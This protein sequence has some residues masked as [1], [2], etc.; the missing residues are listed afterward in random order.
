MAGT[1]I[2]GAH[3][4]GITLSD[5]KTENPATIAVGGYVTNEGSANNG[6]ALF[7]TAA[8]AWTITNL[9]R[10]NGKSGSSSNGIQLRAGGFVTNGESGLASGLIT[11][12]LYGIEIEGKPGTVVNYGQIL[13]LGRN[14]GG[15][16][17]KAGGTVFSDGLIEGTA[18]GVAIGGGAG[19]V[20]NAGTIVSPAGN[21]VALLSGGAV[22]N[23]GK[24]QGRASGIEII[25]KAG[26]VTN[27]GVILGIGTGVGIC[28][29][30]G[31]TVT[32][33]TGGRITA[34]A[35]DGVFV[36]GGAA[37]VTNLGL[38]VGATATSGAAVYL[39]GGGIVTN[40][41]SGNTLG[42]ICGRRDG[43]VLNN[44]AGR[45]TNFG[46]IISTS[47]V[48]INGSLRGVGVLLGAGGTVVNGAAGK[49]GGRALISAEGI[50]VYVGG[51]A[52]TPRPG[53]VGTVVNYGTIR[54]SGVGAVASSAVVLVSG[55]RVV[56]H[57]LIESAGLTGVAFLNQAGT[58]TNFRSIV[59]NAT[60]PSGVGV[61][62]EDGGLVR[63]EAKALIT[64]A[65]NDGVV[66][67][68]A[69][70]TV[71]NLGIVV[72]GHN[73]DGAAVY[74]GHGGSITNGAS[75][76][77]GGLIIGRRS[78]VV[79][80]NLAGKVTNFGT[81][82]STSTA[83]VGGSSKGAG[84][85][86]GAGG[87]LINGGPGATGALIRAAEFGVYGGGIDGV[88][89]P[90][91]VATVV[92]YG[93][94]QSTGTGAIG[95]SAVRL[96][97]GGTVTNHGLIESAGGRGISFGNKRGTVTNFGSVVSTA[98][99]THGVGVYLQLGGQV[100]NEAGA[101]ISAT[102]DDS[103]LVK[104]G[105]AK[106]VNLGTIEDFKKGGVAVYLGGG[107]VVI[108]GANGGPEGAIVS[109]GSGV[110]VAHAAGRVTNFGWITSTGSA[111]SGAVAVELL[112]G[113]DVINRGLIKSAEGSAIAIDHEAGSVTNS[114][115]VVST[116]IGTAGAAI[117]LQDGGSVVNRRG[118]LVE[119]GA[120]PGILVKRAAGTVINSGTIES[121]FG[122]GVYLAAG[123]SLTNQ[124]GALIDGGVHGVYLTNPNGIVINHGT[125]EGGSAGFATLGPGHETLINFG[126]IE[127]TAG[128]AR[129]AVEI[130]G[131]VGG[132][133]LI[134]E[135][136]AVFVGA[137]LGGG[138][139]EIEFIGAVADMTAVDG[140]AKIV[141]A[142]GVH[143]SLTLTAANFVD[144][145]GGVITV[146]DGNRG[147]TV[148]AA[149]V[150]NAII[151]HAGSGADV[152]IG[153][154]GNDIFYAGGRT[155]M[156]GGTGTNEFVFHHPG[157]NTI[158]DFAISTTNEL[159]FSNN[160]FDLGLKNATMTPMVLPSRLV[161]AN[162]T[163]SFTN[164]HQRFAYDTSNGDLFYSATGTTAN[165]HLVVVL[166]GAP[167]LTTTPN[168]HLFYIT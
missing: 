31:G 95:S 166:T 59:S 78:G 28:L 68:N 105:R 146:F 140:F 55:G 80:K 91:A 72:G 63:N 3:L 122:N 20:S 164:K 19:T 75:G 115:S 147:N 163:G 150:A 22:T 159:V 152:L 39:G 14:G 65:R 167:P 148:S 26:T 12:N 89:K 135:P 98:T 38:I 64:A 108:N 117:Y 84:V 157:R 132:T 15:V 107:G 99:G 27:S 102:G 50:G 62:L 7:G 76:T 120:N 162:S 11:A 30:Q 149:G 96:V 25:G 57:G 77:A 141:L 54:S 123:G 36:M 155:T 16:A 74:L 109:P 4:H 71:V 40:G 90:G 156:T 104:S 8:A 45:V 165:E 10:I 48:I 47:K 85:V 112:A 134:V 127:S 32:N 106:L 86:L 111:P 121:L 52:G 29:D 125:I 87:T 37:I 151:I 23:A 58:V 88:P 43:V 124:R 136:H 130:T 138:K 160:G 126:T 110:V 70:G 113:G 94:I 60:G 79:L 139:S 100:T 56:N 53:A 142:N 101:V 129:V 137:V 21:G 145:T 34:A 161:V 6:T 67:K 35:G 114:G 66:V 1:I 92:N 128:T 69:A 51:F 118:G 18:N 97:S 44:A 143:H 61:Y 116:P 131:S 168:T 93:T 49:S 33:E 154:A 158:T 119:S 83:I 5:K 82:E 42:L 13:G 81:I 144:V 73:S 9:G 103:V 41:K 153:G 2:N 24:V 133:V 46:T 17:L